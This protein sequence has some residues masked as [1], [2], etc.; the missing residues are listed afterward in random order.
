MVATSPR[1]LNVLS[2]VALEGDFNP[3]HLAFVDLMGFATI[4]AVAAVAGTAVGPDPYAAALAD[5][6]R[7]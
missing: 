5:A 4:A 1:A 6:S 7:R 3:V 2:G